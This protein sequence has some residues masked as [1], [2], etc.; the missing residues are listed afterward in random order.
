MKTQISHLRSGTRN[1]F[2]NS[3]ID[4]SKLPAASSHIGHGG[5]NS[6]EVR[7]FWDKV[8]LENPESMKIKIMDIEIVLTANW[9]KS[10]KSVVYFGSLEKKDLE[11][12]FCV[13]SAINE[14]PAISIHSANLI[15]VTNGKNGNIYICPSL[16]EIL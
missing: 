9:S 10:R 5:S 1:Q 7:Q 13:K 11:E 15:S 12:K 14:T 8:T 16:I 3:Q 4:Y 6:T 2:L